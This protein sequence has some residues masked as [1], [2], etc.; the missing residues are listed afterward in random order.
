MARITLSIVNVLAIVFLLVGIVTVS[1]VSASSTIGPICFAMT[2]LASGNP[3]VWNYKLLFTVD[4]AIGKTA[5][6][7]G[8][9][10]GLG[11]PPGAVTGSGFLDAD[12]DT[13][14]MLLIQPEI[15]TT[16]SASDQPLGIT[17]I[18]IRFSMAT[19]RGGGTCATTGFGLDP[20]SFCG[21]GLVITFNV[22][23]CNAGMA[24]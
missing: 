2:S 16:H 7:T 21:R 18:E 11:L 8:S 3:P 12:G 4:D 19:G 9:R 15:F 22:E 13:V 24:F 10:E 17:F 20:G 1:N 23:S 5:T 6:V 14:H